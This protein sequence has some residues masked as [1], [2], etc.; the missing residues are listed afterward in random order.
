MLVDPAPRSRLPLVA[1]L[2]DSWTLSIPEPDEAP[3]RSARRHRP[4]VVLLVVHRGEVQRMQR[5]AR[6]L[7]TEAGTP[8][9]V[10]LVDPRN[11]VRDARA[12][13]DASGADGYLGGAPTTERVQ[14]FA[15]ALAA[16]E[17]PF[18]PGDAAPGPRG[19][20]G[21]LFSR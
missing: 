8:P 12:L 18:D 1:A 4:A 7:K 13:L 9:P 6:Q 20:L 21:R 14:A 5:I 16:G 15:A 2:R 11:R 3:V 17:H 10:G 19:L